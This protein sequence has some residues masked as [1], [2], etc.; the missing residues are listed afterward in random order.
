VLVDG[1]AETKAGKPGAFDGMKVDEKGHLF[2]TGP[3]GIWIIAPDGTVLGVIE[4]GQPTANLAWGEDGSVLY[5]TS[6]KEL[7]R[8]KTATRGKMP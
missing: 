1:L 7:F 4:M 2:A 3:G 5:I 6:N 8:M